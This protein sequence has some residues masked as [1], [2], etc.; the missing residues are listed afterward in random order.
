MHTL[1]RRTMCNFLAF[2]YVFP[3]RIQSGSHMNGDTDEFLPS[4]INKSE[5]FF[6]SKTH[7][8]RHTWTHLRFGVNTHKSSNTHASCLINALHHKTFLCFH[9]ALIMPSFHM[10]DQ[11]LTSLPSHF[12]SSLLTEWICSPFSKDPPSQALVWSYLDKFP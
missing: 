10:W 4:N 9:T 2:P 6:E 12:R 3:K 1:T 8:V 5:Q 11:G 7:F